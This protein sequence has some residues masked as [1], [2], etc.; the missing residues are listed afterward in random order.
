M[1]RQ[2]YSMHNIIRF[3]TDQP[4]LDKEW[5]AIHHFFQYVDRQ[6]SRFDPASE[7]SRLNRLLIGQSLTVSLPLARLLQRAIRYFEQTEHYFSPFLL[8]QQYANGY[9]RSF[10][11]HAA[12]EIE[13]T[14]PPDISPFLVEGCEVTRVGGGSID[15]GGIGKGAAAMIVAQRLRKSHTRG[16]IEAGGD[17]IVWSDA[18]PW[19]IA[20]T[21]PQTEQAIAEVRLRQGAVAT[22]NRIYR[23][24]KVGERTNHHLLSGKTGRPIE[25]R[26]VQ[27]TA[28]A[29]QLYEAEVMTKLA[30]QMTETERQDK[31]F[32]WFPNGR[33]LLMDDSGKMV[34]EEK[35]GQSIWTG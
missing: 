21:D 16:L 32:K 30:F 3:V 34:A 28:S 17:V 19:K 24:W 26:Y 12:T 5:Q 8:E 6:W 27:I 25:T 14:V 4:I 35:G 7:I 20:I 13:G 2:L 9:D 10:P 31:L 33:L 1:D 11:F 15:L 23:S 18:H 22:S 29:P